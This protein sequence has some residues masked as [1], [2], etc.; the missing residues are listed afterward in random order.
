MTGL[1]LWLGLISYAAILT[2]AFWLS[3]RLF[4]YR[5]P[6]LRSHIAAAFTVTGGM[7]F[8][9]VLNFWGAG[10]A[11]A[12]LI[13]ASL[14][15]LPLFAI[16]WLYVAFLI[17]HRRRPPPLVDWIW[18]GGLMVS[19]FMLVASPLIGIWGIG[20][21]CDV[22]HIHQLGEVAQGLVRYHEVEGH[23]PTELD[24][25]I[26]RFASTRPALFCFLGA[27]HHYGLMEC[28]ERTILVLMNF[29]GGFPIRY[30][31]I[32]DRWS[33]ISFL[34]GECNFLD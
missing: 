2:Y 29:T 28:R 17:W 27:S 10:G 33:S 23:Y 3:I 8:F 26:P 32:H 34:D 12:I 16:G 15:T 30:D 31:P 9:A 7:S 14:C 6:Q 11:S 4:D 20:T 22:I 13:F 25:V 1:L 24:Q 5:L 21:S 19:I 18:R